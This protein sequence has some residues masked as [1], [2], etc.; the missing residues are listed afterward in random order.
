ML[1]VALTAI[2]L[3]LVL[4]LGICS[5]LYFRQRAM[6]YYPTPPVDSKEAV[7]V[8]LSHQGER[9]KIWHV[10]H[11]GTKAILY[12]GG[13]AEEVS[14]NLPR[15]R[16]LFPDHALYLANYRGY[17]GSTGSPSEEALTA[18]AA[19][20]YDF[21]AMQHPE[22]TVIGRSLGTGVA[23]FLASERPVNRLVLV[24]PYDSMAN[25]AAEIYPIFPVRLLIQDRYDSLGRAPGLTMDILLLI[26][27]HDEV[28][29]R[30][31][32]EALAASLPSENTRVRI[33]PTADHNT[34]DTVPLYDRLLSAFINGTGEGLD[35]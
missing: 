8:W 11:E 3:L 35:E 13:N 22:I 14:L 28:V 18:D 4:Y 6:I 1:K 29:P 2:A 24:T 19:L 17:G 12:F 33:I 31:R 26:A 34:I 30:A 15:F 10:P 25:L 9:L 5:L 21:A 20:L 16:R 32:S 7:A 23:V 27:E